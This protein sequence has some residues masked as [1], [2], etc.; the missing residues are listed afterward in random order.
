MKTLLQEIEQMVV[1]Y[2]Q[3][4]EDHHVSSSFYSSYYSGN[5]ISDSSLI[6]HCTPA[7]LANVKL[8]IAELEPAG[9]VY[10]PMF[11]EETRQKVKALFI[12]LHHIGHFK[13]FS[14]DIIF[15]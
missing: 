4:P 10:K 12:M 2:I 13:N 7:R 5:L 3:N 8:M 9:F 11:S 1:R 14:W 6:E 15:R